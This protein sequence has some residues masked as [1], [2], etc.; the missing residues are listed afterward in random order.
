MSMTSGH[1]PMLCKKGPPAVTTVPSTYFRPFL[2]S[3]TV[4]NIIILFDSDDSAV[5]PMLLTALSFPL[6]LSD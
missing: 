1:S 2:F 4:E 6:V 5:V 3:F